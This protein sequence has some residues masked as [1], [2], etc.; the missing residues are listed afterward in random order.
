MAVHVFLTFPVI[1]ISGLGSGN[2]PVTETTAKTDRGVHENYRI[3]A[4]NAGTPEVTPVTPAQ[5]KNT[6]TKKQGNPDQ[7]ATLD[8][9]GVGIGI[10]VSLIVI[11]V[12]VGLVL[13]FRKKKTESDSPI[14]PLSSP[15]NPPTLP[16]TSPSS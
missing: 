14:P 7:R 11:T 16:E 13:E 1:A 4:R 8:G 2:L 12:I 3:F 5:H 10:T 9:F 15:A 6:T